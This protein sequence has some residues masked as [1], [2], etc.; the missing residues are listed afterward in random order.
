MAIY[1]VPTQIIFAL[2]QNDKY[3]LQDQCYENYYGMI[4]NY[5]A[6]LGV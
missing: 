6:V 2:Y 4:Y 5:T 1:L 3:P